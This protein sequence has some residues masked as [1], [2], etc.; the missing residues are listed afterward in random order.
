MRLQRRVQR[1]LQC[2]GPLESLRAVASLAARAVRAGSG[3]LS[4]VTAAAH[5]DDRQ[6]LTGLCA[7]MMATCAPAANL[8][9]AMTRPLWW[10]QTCARGGTAAKDMLYTGHYL[11]LVL[12]LPGEVGNE[13]TAPSKPGTHLERFGPA[14]LEPGSVAGQ[15]HHGGCSSGCGGGSGGGG[16]SRWAGRSR[17][18]ARWALPLEAHRRRRSRRAGEETQRWLGWRT[19]NSNGALDAVEAHGQ[20]AG[21]NRM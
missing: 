11:E 3:H 10:S 15:A 20:D 2:M 6:S 12:S 21:T 13:R 1:R 8:Y 14:I 5:G 17:G 19:S 7:A 16:E 18:R 9:A 4:K